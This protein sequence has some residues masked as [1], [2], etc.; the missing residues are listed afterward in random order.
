ME[1]EFLLLVGNQQGDDEDE[2]DDEEGDHHG[3]HGRHRHWIWGERVLYQIWRSEDVE[4]C[5]RCRTPRIS[6]PLGYL[7]CVCYR[8]HMVLSDPRVRKGR[9]PTISAEV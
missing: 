3:Y 1:A 6:I 8:W 2:E 9:Q 7:R 5:D 4:L